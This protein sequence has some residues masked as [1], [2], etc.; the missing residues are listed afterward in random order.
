MKLGKTYQDNRLP[1]FELPV[2]LHEGKLYRLI[3]NI[4][5]IKKAADLDDG[6]RREDLHSAMVEFVEGNLV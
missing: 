6:S 2:E 3:A 5:I 1:V 4:M